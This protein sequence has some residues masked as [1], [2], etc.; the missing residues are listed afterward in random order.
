M[1][2]ELYEAYP[3]TDDA[4]ALLTMA[5]IPFTNWKKEKRQRHHDKKDTRGEQRGDLD[6]R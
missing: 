3:A 1:L 5:N 6:L 4:A 2:K